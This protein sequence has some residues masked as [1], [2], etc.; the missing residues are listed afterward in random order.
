MRANLKQIDATAPME[1]VGTGYTALMH[2]RSMRVAA[3]VGRSL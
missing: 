1:L 2:D 3:M